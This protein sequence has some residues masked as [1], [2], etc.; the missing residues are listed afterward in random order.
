M[1]AQHCFELRQVFY[2][3]FVF[4]GLECHDFSDLVNLWTVNIQFSDHS[5]RAFASDE[6]LLEVIASIVLENL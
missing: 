6:K 2:D 1:F 4:V 3:V 5:H